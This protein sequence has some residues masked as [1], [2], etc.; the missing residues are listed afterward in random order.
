M[1]ARGLRLH[2]LTYCVLTLRSLKSHPSL[3]LAG[4]LL[5]TTSL[6]N[7]FEFYWI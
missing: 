6:K 5:A 3:P 2:W 4:M 1:S 7:S